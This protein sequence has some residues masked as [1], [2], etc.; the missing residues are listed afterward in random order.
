MTGYSFFPSKNL[1]AWGDAGMMVT[2]DDAAADRLKKLRLHGGAKQYHHD[3]VGT[4][5]RLDTLQAAVLLAKLPYL[6]QWSAKRREHASYYTKALA[7]LRQVKPP[8]VDA[9]NEHIFH[10]YTLRAER[11]DELQA[12]LKKEG[13]GHAVY[14]PIPLHRQPCFAHLGYTDGSLPHAEQAAREAISLPIYPELTRAQLDRV[15]D[16]IR[17]FY[18]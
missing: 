7:E 1:G 17:G 16:A 15:I 9:A 3:E 11:R 5:S 13:I 6:A 12:H 8:V 10:Q 18:R 4:N 2:S 14:Y